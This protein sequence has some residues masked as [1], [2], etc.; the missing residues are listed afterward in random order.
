MARL[1]EDGETLEL[2]HALGY[3][4]ELAER[5]RSFPVAASLPLSDAVRERRPVYV[6]TEAERR[7]LYPELAAVY[8]VTPQRRGPTCR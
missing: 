7:E 1:D 2:V 5:F 3:P 8:P 6:T 4:P